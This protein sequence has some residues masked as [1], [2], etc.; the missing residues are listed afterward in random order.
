MKK[1]EIDAAGGRVRHAVRAA[2]AAR[3]RHQEGCGTRG[4]AIAEMIRNKM[5][6]ATRPP[7]QAP[8]WSD[9]DYKVC[10]AWTSSASSFVALPRGS[11][12]VSSRS[13]RSTGGHAACSFGWWLMV[14]ADLL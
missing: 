1:Q 4:P 9:C 14:G 10:H 7:R 13:A 5:D 11:E 6:R 8:C 2:V 12:R 3:R